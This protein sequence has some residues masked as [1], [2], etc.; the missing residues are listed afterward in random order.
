MF[1][2]LSLVSS[3]RKSLEKE[4]KDADLFAIEVSGTDKFLNSAR[5]KIDKWNK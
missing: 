5:D 2:P 3:I 4:E 1:S